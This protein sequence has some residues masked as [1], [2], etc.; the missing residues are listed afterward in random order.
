MRVFAFRGRAGRKEYFLHWLGGI[1]A[2]LGSVFMVV[3]TEMDPMISP[4]V[5]NAMAYFFLLVLVLVLID[6]IGVSLR[7][8][9][10]LGRP[11][12]HFWLLFVPIYNI[13][14]GLQFFFKR[15]V[16]N[17][18]ERQSASLGTTTGVREEELTAEY[19]CGRCGGSITYGDAHCPRC[20]DT[21][22]F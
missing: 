3:W 7:R 21:I 16:Y 6:D 17:Q 2:Y 22:E 5:K 1:V 9:E 13:Y 18:T 20:G 10:D 4:V 11:R 14:L 19:A 12:W 8:L 15:G